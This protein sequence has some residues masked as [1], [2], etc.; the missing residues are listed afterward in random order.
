MIYGKN[1]RQLLDSKIDKIFRYVSK[2][3]NYFDFEIFRKKNF[4]EDIKVVLSEFG[5]Y[6]GYLKRL[7]KF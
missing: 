7:I 4:F 2:F 1:F 3:F 5:T 6:P